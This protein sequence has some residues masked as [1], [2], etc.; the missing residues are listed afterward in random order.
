MNTNANF[1]DDARQIVQDY[2]EQRVHYEYTM[3]RA[4]AGRRSGAYTEDYE[5][6]V[7]IDCEN[8]MANLRGVARQ[9]LTALEQEFKTDLLKRTAPN[10]AELDGAD[11]RLLSSGLPMSAAEFSALCE[12][13]ASNETVLR[14]AGSYAAQHDMIPYFRQYYHTPTERM[15]AFAH[16]VKTARVALDAQRQ[17]CSALDPKHWACVTGADAKVI[18]TSAEYYK[19]KTGSSSTTAPT[20]TAAANS[21]TAWSA[22]DSTINGVT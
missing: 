12:R 15:D 21:N 8:A 11:F 22:Q 14:A 16:I 3:E 7:R 18:G 1:I 19:G 13:N 10:G 2:F 4:A 9:R 20:T 6:G 17:Y 5:R